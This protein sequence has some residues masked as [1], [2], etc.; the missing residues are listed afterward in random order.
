MA[1]APII[2]GDR[3]LARTLEHLDCQ[4]ETLGT[5]GYLALGQPGSIASTVMLGLL[6]LFVALIGIRFLFGPGPGMRDLVFDVLKIGIVLTL[7][8]SWPA[9]RTL[10]HDVVIQG[11]GEIAAVIAAPGLPDGGLPVTERLQA[12][13]T[14]MVTLTELGTGRNTGAYIDE[15]PGAT[16]AGTALA[17]DA[18][19]GWARLVFLGSTI[20]AWGL[21]RIAAGL[22]L[23][24]GPL[25]AGLLLFGATRGL[26][27]G[28]LKGLV[29]AMIG[30]I[31]LGIVLAVELA[32]LEPWLAD[33][34]RVRSL[35]YAT[36]SGPIEL[37]ALTGAF[38]AVQFG[39]IALLAKVA[40]TRGW[41]DIRLPE[42][43]LPDMQRAV[44]SQVPLVQPA[45]SESRAQ[46]TADSV[47][48]LVERERM[49]DRARVSYRTL[50]SDGRLPPGHTGGGDVGLV[51]PSERLGSS[52]RRTAHRSSNAARRRDGRK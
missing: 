25:A 5:Y 23:A 1:C 13:D 15:G 24:L 14:A 9:F 7:A 49:G 18:A 22:L 51:G 17:D 42:F 39:M 32:L 45:Y 27:A 2:T 46:R 28:W 21:V 47:E 48:R 31:G 41:P 10:V 43:Q 29:L 19:L 11:P 40:F 3:F 12:A 52:Y 38:A 34:V 8:F 20:G 44:G 6:T 30:G 35:G 50:G 36:P 37:F 33:A 16:F 26:F 4:A